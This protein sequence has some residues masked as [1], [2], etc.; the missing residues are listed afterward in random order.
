M[1]FFTPLAILLSTM[2]VVLADND[3]E[4]KFT[5][6]ETQ[7]VLNIS[8]PVLF[9]WTLPESGTYRA[10]DRMNLTLTVDVTNEGEPMSLMSLIAIDIDLR[11]LSYEWHPSNF[12]KDLDEISA[13]LLSGNHNQ[14]L[15][16]IGGDPNDESVG[17]VAHAIEEVGLEGYHTMAPAES[18]ASVV[19]RSMWAFSALPVIVAVAH[20]MV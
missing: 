4:I 17:F 5:T 12:T 13:T 16:E 10:F 11:S 18:G 20:G 2:T 8:A 7:Q 6:P 3:Q 9:E 19:G 15:A 14:V 1:H